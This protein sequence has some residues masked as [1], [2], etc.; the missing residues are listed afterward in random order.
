MIE[1]LA[2]GV[3]AGLLARAMFGADKPGLLMTLLAGF[4][5]SVLGFL[6]AHEVLGLHEMHL[7]APEGLLPAGAAAGLLLLLGNRLRRAH[8][9]RTIFG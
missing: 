4:G 5:G 9:R 3:A 7:F 1:A 6:L 2:W 8:R